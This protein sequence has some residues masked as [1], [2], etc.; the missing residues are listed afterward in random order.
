MKN[1]CNTYMSII[2]IIKTEAQTTI[3]TASANGTLGMDKETLARTCS[4]LGAVIDSKGA[5]GWEILKK[6]IQTNIDAELKTK[7]KGIRR[8]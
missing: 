3:A 1:T 4:I 8:P 7:R 6:N 5:E 2:D